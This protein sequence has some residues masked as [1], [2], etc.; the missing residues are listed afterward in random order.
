MIRSFTDGPRAQMRVMTNEA[1]PQTDELYG[2]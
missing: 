1:T 2:E